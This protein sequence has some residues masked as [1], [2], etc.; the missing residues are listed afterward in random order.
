[1]NKP[2]CIELLHAKAWMME[3]ADGKIRWARSFGAPVRLR[4]ATQISL[5]ICGAK[6][7]SF[8]LLNA[9]LMETQR[10]ET[11]RLEIDIGDQL[12]ERNKV[13][14]VWGSE[15]SSDAIADGFASLSSVHLE[16]FE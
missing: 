7:P 6:L 8:V 1:V 9:A 2:H 5:C 16:I 13:E 14:L 4:S 10:K 11:E 12:L 3:S 15:I